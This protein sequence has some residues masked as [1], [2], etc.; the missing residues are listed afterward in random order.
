[1]PDQTYWQRH[2]EAC[3]RGD[4]TYEDPETGY[5]V[6]TKLGL[7]DRDRCCGAGCRHCPFDHDNVKF[8]ARARKIQQAAWLTEVRPDPDHDVTVIFWSGGKD[9]YLAYRALLKA[10]QT[11]LVLLTT[12]DARSRIIA[13]Q[14]FMID[15]V[16]EQAKCLNV[17][18]IGVPLH[19]GVDHTDQI[20]QALD[21][22][23]QCRQLSF[24]DLHLQHIRNWREETFGAHP[25]TSRLQLSFP[26]W[27][28][29]YSALLADLLSS[30]RES[31]VSAVSADVQDVKVGDRFDAA[32]IARLPDHI[33]AFGENGEFHT[34]IVFE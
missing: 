15:D 28:A 27:N 21:L 12:F 3:D 13:H 14:E 23:P 2:E 8:E 20:V 18:L 24:G 5:V 11:N 34:R 7:L 9:S 1:M 4:F 32:F 29:D 31:I 17:P 26:L 25:G 19:S 16:V 30:G 6:F 33:D 22:V 10:G